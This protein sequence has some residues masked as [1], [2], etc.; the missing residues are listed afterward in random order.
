MQQEVPVSQHEVH[1]VGH[2][3]A[4]LLVSA[5]GC[6]PTGEGGQQ[7]ALKVQEMQLQLDVCYLYL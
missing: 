5:Y 4:Y 7:E 2:E 6:L 1:A 3:E